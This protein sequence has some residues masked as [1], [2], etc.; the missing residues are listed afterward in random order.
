MLHTL[1]IFAPF[2]ERNVLLMFLLWLLGMHL[3]VNMSTANRNI[4]RP[5]ALIIHYTHNNQ[6]ISQEELILVDAGCEY[7]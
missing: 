6:L 5:N 1:I 4:S 2:Q 3:S 7:K